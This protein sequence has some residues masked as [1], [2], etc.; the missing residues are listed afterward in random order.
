MSCSWVRASVEK[1]SDTSSFREE[2][3]HV[4]EIDRLRRPYVR[5][6]MVDS[7]IGDRLVLVGG[8]YVDG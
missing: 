7:G 2:P 3:E 1:G 4:S 8:G 6:I 5:T